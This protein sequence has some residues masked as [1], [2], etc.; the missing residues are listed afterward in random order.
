VEDSEEEV[1]LINNGGRK[2]W[3]I[4]I[5]NSLLSEYGV[6]GFDYGYAL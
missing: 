3:K 5:Y 6:L 1:I 2:Y 4:C